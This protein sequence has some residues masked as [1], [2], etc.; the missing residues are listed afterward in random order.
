VRTQWLVGFAALVACS[1]S[2][3]SSPEP[4]PLSGAT[5]AGEASDAVCPVAFPVLPHYDDPACPIAKPARADVMDD[6]LA[7]A[8]LDRCTLGYT[9]ADW[10]IYPTTMTEDP[11]RLPWFDAVHDHAMRAP[12]FGRLLSESLDLGAASPTPVASA[13]QVAAFA[14][15]ATSMP[16]EPPA[17]VDGAQP[18]ARA[19]AQIVR[20]GGAEPDDAALEADAA[21]VPLALQSEIARIVLAAGAAQATWESLAGGLSA[22][23][24]ATLSKMHAMFLRS[25]GGPP[26]VTSKNAQSL[27]S[28]RFDVEALVRGGATLALAIERAHLSRFA[29]LSGFSF[30]QETPLGRVVIRDAADDVHAAGSHVLLSVDSGGNDTYRDEAGAVDG[31]AAGER[32]HHVGI[33]I[34]LAGHDTYGYDAVPDA[35]DGA[36]L[37]ADRGGRLHPT[38]P[39]SD[40][41][42]PVSLSETLRQGAARLGYGMLFDLGD[43]DDTYRSLRLS[44]GYGVAGVGV[45]YDEAGNDR[46]DGEA[47][48]QGASHLGVGLLIDG[49]GDDHYH[50]YSQTQG[51]AGIR[52]VGILYDGDGSDH[53]VADNGN[54]DDGG[55]PLYWTIQMP[56]KGNNSFAQGSAWGRRPPDSDDVAMSGGLG[57][58]RDRAGD[59]V[60]V[61][62]VQTQGSGYWFGTGLLSDGAGNDQYDARY[63]MQGAGAHFAMAIFLEG[64]GNDRYDQTFAPKATSIGV[65][66]DFTVAWHVDLGGDDVYRAPPLS[67]GSGNANGIGVLVN[68][69][70]NDVYQSAAEPSLGAA[71]FS[72]EWYGACD[73]CKKVATTGIFVDV[74]GADRYDVPGSIIAHADDEAWANRTSPASYGVTEHS[75]GL[76]RAAGDVALP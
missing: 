53:Y 49:R 70:G 3:P 69:G 10:S 63:Y 18:L 61:S 7:A 44:Q 16:C 46:Y 27:L 67:L 22:S 59:D 36:R 15:G 52:S 74:G 14:F 26:A 56:G 34:D 29:G 47:A 73:A 20:D 71:S 24:L 12:G 75:A 39:L 42:G 60:Y 48:V 5:D 32:K 76:D 64:G 72:A 40:A 41:D 51:F 28:K 35:L 31:A 11:Y 54:P 68:V 50:S 19:V 66:H 1:P 38:E 57:I 65:G 33:A 4:A 25:T 45:L 13:L 37:P 23:D 58:L 62:S 30:E 17:A 8:G 55:D 6:A 9:A 2:S 21:D 43:G